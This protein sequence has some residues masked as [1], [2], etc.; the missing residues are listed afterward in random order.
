VSRNPKELTK[1]EVIARAEAL[2]A[3][4]QDQI[5]RQ[6]DSINRLL[7]TQELDPPQ[8]YEDEMLALN[9]AII[10][11]DRR[12][13]VDR[14]KLRRLRSS[15]TDTLDTTLLSP[16]DR[17]RIKGWLEIITEGEADARPNLVGTS[18]DAGTSEVE[19]LG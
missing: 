10:D 4:R 5:A 13:M 1:A 15:M 7:G 16:R 18:P 9:N 14:A 2:D 6:I 8:R 11:L 3:R 19:T 17:E 12:G